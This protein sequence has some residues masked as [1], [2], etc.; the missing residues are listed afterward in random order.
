MAPSVVRDVKVFSRD[1]FVSSWDINAEAIRIA[2]SPNTIAT[3]VSIAVYRSALPWACEV[4]VSYIFF[5]FLFF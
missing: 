2:K 5:L 4:T 1:P 3:V